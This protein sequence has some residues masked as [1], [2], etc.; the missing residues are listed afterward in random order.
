MGRCGLLDDNKDEKEDDL[1][2]DE[3]EDD[4][5]AQVEREEREV[6]SLASKTACLEGC[7]VC[8]FGRPMS[9]II[10]SLVHYQTDKKTATGAVPPNLHFSA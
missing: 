8:H 5:D 6:A 3:H 4:D 2:V 9:I 7:N 10:I 1:V